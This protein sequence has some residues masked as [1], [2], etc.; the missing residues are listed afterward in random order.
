LDTFIRGLHRRTADLHQDWTGRLKRKTSGEEARSEAVAEMLLRLR[1]DDTDDKAR[2]KLSK[3]VA[4][5]WDGLEGLDLTDRQPLSSA[6]WLEDI[7]GVALPASIAEVTR[8]KDEEIA[9]LL[10][11]SSQHEQPLQESASYQQPV[12]SSPTEQEEETR[13]ARNGATYIRAEFL[14]YYGEVQGMTMW[15]EALPHPRCIESA[16]EPVSFEGE[17]SHA[18]RAQVARAA[19]DAGLQ[20]S[21]DGLPSDLRRRMDLFAADQ[22]AGARVKL[23]LGLTAMQ[24]KAVH[25]WAEMQGLEHK[26]FGYRGRRRLHLA[27][28]GRR[29]DGEDAEAFDFAAW[30]DA[31]EDEEEW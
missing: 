22:R 26:S 9:S 3:I 7:E 4:R 18:A 16:D 20:V 31:E 23:P 15:E 2:A 21:L 25:L 19:M 30:N 1:W 28:S 12:C 10:V 8:N 11:E 17:T 5:I 14:E 6:L 24:R 27:V 13:V 29:D